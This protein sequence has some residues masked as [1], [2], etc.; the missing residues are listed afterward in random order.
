MKTNRSKFLFVLALGLGV[1]LL[2]ACKANFVTDIDASG[3]GTFT[4]EIGFSPDEAS[5]AGLSDTG[6]FCGAQ[7]PASELPPNTAIRQETRGEE[8]WCIY[9]TPFASLDELR[10]IYGRM[11]VG[12]VDLRIEDGQASYN[13]SVDPGSDSTVSSFTDIYWIVKMP[14]DV[15][16]TNSI[17]VDGNTLRWRLTPGVLTSTYAYSDVGGNT[18]W[19]VV[20]IGLACLCLVVVIGIGA[21]VFFLL[22]RKKA[23]AAAPAPAAAE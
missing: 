2:S 6:D 17:E 3:S 20:G 19:W 4:Q 15:T 23:G 18:V 11:D 22:R 1:L 14:G 13:V 5:M 8:T 16:D 9:E 10:S 7:I 12:I 21:A